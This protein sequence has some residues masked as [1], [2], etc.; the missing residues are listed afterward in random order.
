MTKRELC[1]L[2]GVGQCSKQDLTVS[3][4]QL[5]ETIAVSLKLYI[6]RLCAK[7]SCSMQCITNP[8]FLF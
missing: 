7:L 8:L 4:K 2:N 3:K 6:E 5:S 1:T